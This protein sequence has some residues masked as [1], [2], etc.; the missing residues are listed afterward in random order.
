MRNLLIGG[1]GFIGTFLSK[2]LLDQK[3]QVVSL[4]SERK[5][6]IN[7]V[8]TTVCNLYESECPQDILDQSDNVFILIGQVG[9]NFDPDKELAVMQKLA[10]Q[11]KKSTGRVI[12]FSTSHVYGET[13]GS[14]N[15]QSQCAPIEPYARY[16]LAAESMLCSAIPENRLIILR[17]S[18]IYGSP[19]NRGIIGAVINKIRQDKNAVITLNYQGKHRR[20]YVLVD[21]LVKAVLL[22]VKNRAAQGVV[23]IA[24]GQTYSNQEVVEMLSRAMNQEINQQLIDGGPEEAAITELSNQKLQKLIGS[25]EFVP[26]QR[27]LDL[28]IKR[29]DQAV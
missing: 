16:K 22:I 17:L 14:A 3:Q 7:G 25:F 19:K 27:G 15:E 21:D 23:N 11:L 1:S 5:G 26:L 4:S 13:N 10:A 9:P 18:N 24:T 29:Y 6:E 12:F 2:A 20:D 28:T 8:E